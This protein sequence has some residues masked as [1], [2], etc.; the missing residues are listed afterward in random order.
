MNH[1]TAAA[2]GGTPCESLPVPAGD[3]SPFQWHLNP[4]RSS[5]KVTRSRPPGSGSGCGSGNGRSPALGPGPGGTGAREGAATIAAAPPL[6]A[7]APPHQE[8]HGIWGSRVALP[9]TARRKRRKKR[10]RTTWGSGQDC[11]VGYQSALGWP[12]NF[13]QRKG[14]V[15]GVRERLRQERLGTSSE[16]E[17]ASEKESL[18]S[19][20][21]LPRSVCL[22][23]LSSWETNQTPL[24]GFDGTFVAVI[25]GMWM[26]ETKV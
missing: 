18:H 3:G 5:I 14:Q 12:A 20:R 24:A 13:R 19:A 6:G 10:R 21:L 1:V 23:P 9:G 17:R 4:G 15:E 7:P 25:I 8:L 26:F 2:N 22:G 11:G 16:S